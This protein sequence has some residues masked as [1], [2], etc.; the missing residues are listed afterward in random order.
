[1]TPLTATYK[2]AKGISLAL[3]RMFLMLLSGEN[4]VIDFGGMDRCRKLHE[5][6]WKLKECCLSAS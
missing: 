6:E 2:Q 4:G 5:M 1:M 3:L